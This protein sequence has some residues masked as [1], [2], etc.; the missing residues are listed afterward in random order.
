MD[1]IF[2]TM[3][4]NKN[5]CDQKI[6]RFFIW[7]FLIVDLKVDNRFVI[8]FYDEM[9]NGETDVYSMNKN[10]ICFSRFVK[11]KY[12]CYVHNECIKCSQFLI[13]NENDF[14]LN[15]KNK[16]EGES[17]HCIFLNTKVLKFNEFLYFFKII[18]EISELKEN[19]KMC[20]FLLILRKLE[21]FKFKK[22]KNFNLIVRNL[23]LSIV[24]NSKY[25]YANNNLKGKTIVST[26]M[27]KLLFKEFGRIYFLD[28]SLFFENASGIKIKEILNENF[29]INFIFDPK[30][31]CINSTFITV[32][33]ELFESNLEFLIS[34]RIIFANIRNTRAILYGNRSSIRNISSRI[35]YI[36]F[37]NIEKFCF[38]SWEDMNFFNSMCD[39]LIYKKVTILIFFRCRFS[40]FSE[41]PFNAFK[42]LTRI[43]FINSYITNPISLGKLYTYLEL[44]FSFYNEITNETNAAKIL[45]LATDIQPQFDNIDAVRFFDF[46]KSLMISQEFK[47][48]E[49]LVC[50]VDEIYYVGSYFGIYMS[51]S[52]FPQNVKSISVIF[53]EVS[54][55]GFQLQNPSIFN[56]TRELSILDSEFSN[57]FLLDI[58]LLPHLE[59]FVICNCKALFEKK[60]TYE[61]R[62]SI[63]NFS[64]SG[65]T[66]T[67]S[68]EMINFVNCMPNLKSL[69]L[70]NNKNLYM[71]Q[72][73]STNNMIWSS[74][75]EILMLLDE[76]KFQGVLPNLSC[77]KII[78]NFKFDYG[79]YDEGS[80][81]Q[82]MG[83]QGLINVCNLS[84]YNFK[85]GSRDK[86][87]IKNISEIKNLSFFNCT[88]I[89]ITFSQLFDPT[90]KYTIEKLILER[91]LLTVVDILFL[92]NLA[93]L[94]YLEI[95]TSGFLFQS[96][97]F[98]KVVLLNLS[99]LRIRLKVPMQ[100]LREINY[101]KEVMQSSN[102]EIYEF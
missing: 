64:I 9:N 18:K 46:N 22:D 54:L 91:I 6:V 58:L 19:F 39:K 26:S 77:L 89:N 38:Y 17:D 43:Y 57:E 81:L 15:F 68:E 28:A 4:S 85:I 70:R 92:S 75:L 95:E 79:L 45:K 80:L 12:F 53:K 36:L 48:S 14:P 27:L 72:S 56:T 73:I 52:T 7:I 67:N 30:F 2:R 42:S 65:S 11:K 25:I 97:D 10:S 32:I 49:Y 20:D 33:N 90:K 88:F 96:K 98:S 84:V 51:V 23:L 62:S 37:S 71:F 76:R 41:S 21:V 40:V 86:D 93:C 101:F 99:Q 83:N 94:K 29:D 34:F 63:N 13:E 35:C 100:F 69:T 61:K 55:R 5:I 47:S 24:F 1:K 31:V 60:L 50:L 8:H 44:I 74:S 78:K 59:E 16:D 102:L 3:F 66:F 82:L 87:A